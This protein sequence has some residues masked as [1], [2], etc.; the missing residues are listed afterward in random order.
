MRRLNQHGVTLLEILIAIFLLGVIVLAAALAQRM[1]IYFL[2]STGKRVE[3]QNRAHL[4]MEYIT[5]DARE[6]STYIV[7]GGG[8]RLRLTDPDGNVV[9][10]RFR[11]NGLEYDNSFNFGSGTIEGVTGYFDDPPPLDLHDRGKRFVLHIEVEEEATEGLEDTEKRI[12][13]DVQVFLRS[14]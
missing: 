1:G 14:N 3:I 6:S 7:L 10:Y 12:V 5:R 11:N 8:R 9:T 2:K 4:G 13:L